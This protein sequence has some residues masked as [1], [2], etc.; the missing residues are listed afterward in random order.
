M[1]HADSCPQWSPVAAVAGAWQAA[2]L[3]KVSESMKLKSRIWEDDVHR[4]PYVYG[5]V[6]SMLQGRWGFSVLDE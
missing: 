2:V 4:K 3:L 5:V 1:H 6:G